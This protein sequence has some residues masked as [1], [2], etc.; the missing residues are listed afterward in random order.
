VQVDEWF[1]VN[2]SGASGN[3][4]IL[5]CQGIGTIHYAGIPSDYYYW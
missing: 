5:D 2:L 3:A 4:Q 1:S